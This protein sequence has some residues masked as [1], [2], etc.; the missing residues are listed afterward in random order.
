V[1][2]LLIKLIVKLFYN[3]I[4]IFL[5][6][7]AIKIDIEIYGRKMYDGRWMMYD[8]RWMMYDG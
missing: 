3:K 1:I 7:K 8:G 2:G 4:N 6:S 5:C